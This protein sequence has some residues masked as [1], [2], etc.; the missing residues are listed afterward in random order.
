M[1][2]NEGRVD[3][4][5]ST[6]ESKKKTAFSV[7]P[8]LVRVELDLDLAIALGDHILK[9]RCENPAIVALGHQLQNLDQ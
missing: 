1:Q 3:R 9:V 5:H 6:D 2:I 4:F 7:K 8:P